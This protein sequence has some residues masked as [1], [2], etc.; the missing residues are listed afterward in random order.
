MLISI[1]RASSHP[2]NAK[3]L[4][5]NA[6]FGVLGG[7]FDPIHIGHL[8]LAEEAL[9][10]LRLNRVLFIPS[11]QPPHKSQEPVTRS[12]DRMEMAQRATAPNPGFEVSAME[13]SRLGNS[14]TVDTLTELRERYGS[15]VELYFI[16]GVD[17]VLEM[18]T[19]KDP[20][21]VLELCELVVAARPG[22]DMER[23]D[24]VPVSGL[25]RR[26]HALLSPLMD[27]SSTDIRARV[28]AGRSIR[29]LTPDP[30]IG[31][32]QQAGLYRPASISDADQSHNEG[33]C[34]WLYNPAK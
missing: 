14:Y 29:Y 5:A 31:Y 1:D 32:I 22:F 13:I 11:G 30:V 21:R 17:A 25:A 6:R 27:I 2:Y 23:L 8:R 12:R 16:I 10:Q 4:M 3:V 20:E 15:K 9:E 18:H 33:N 24:R 26:A 28:R 7:T 19:W 34:G